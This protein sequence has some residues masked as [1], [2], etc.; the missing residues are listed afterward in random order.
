[1]KSDRR[2]DKLERKAVDSATNWKIK[3]KWIKENE[4]W[5]KDA[6][7]IALRILDELERR[8]MKQKELAEKLEISPQ[9]I[10][11]IVKGR[12]NLT[13][14]TI[15]KFE[16]ALDIKLLSIE[17]AS[18]QKDRMHVRMVPVSIHF[19]ASKSIYQGNIEGLQGRAKTESNFKTSTLKVSA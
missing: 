19:N 4:H 7:L 6:A 8:G 3:A 16:R 18:S 13:L 11:K 5:R 10:T 9:A 15:R 12:R 14:G 2:R 17:D 1:M